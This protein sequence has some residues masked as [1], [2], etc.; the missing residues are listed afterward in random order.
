MLVGTRDCDEIH[1]LYASGARDEIAASFYFNSWLGGG[2]PSAD[3]LLAELSEIDV[4]RATDPRLDRAI[5]FVSPET[6]GS[7][8]RFE[9]RRG[10]DRELLRALFDDLPRDDTGRSNENS[11]ASYRRYVAMT[12]RRSYFERRD[13]GWSSML[14]Y[15]AGFRL[16]EAVNT[17]RTDGELPEILHAI[18]RGE[19]LARPERLGKGLALRVRRVE[20]G[21]IRSYRVF[22]ASHFEL[23]LRDEAREAPFVEHMP[24]GLLLRYRGDAGAHAELRIDLDVFEMLARLNAGYRPSVEE[25]QGYWLSVSI[26]KNILASAPY[27]EV[28]LTVT[29]HDLYRVV[30]E[31]EGLLLMSRVEGEAN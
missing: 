17:R 18:S 25:E 13:P 7:L 31:D 9:A 19:G 22:P 21:L 27:H 11:T 14:P 5:G 24:S 30:R 6:D 3:R 12:R 28:L 8:M 29:G 10:Y 23:S 20:N 1:A 15:R 26:F 16:L 4:G 2:A